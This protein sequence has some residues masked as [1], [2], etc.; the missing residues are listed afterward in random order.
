MLSHKRPTKTDEKIS[1][2]RRWT[3]EETELFA[4]V[5]SDPDNCYARSLQML[6]LKKSANNELFEHI[7]ITFDCVLD[8]VTFR[9][10]NEKNNF[11]SKSGV[12]TH[13]PKLDTLDKLRK[14]YK[15]LKLNLNLNKVVVSHR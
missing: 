3:S 11:T 6:A 2:A 8:E 13:Y 5:L 9:L 12:I 7:Q 14:K 1:K 15:N 10:R 4:E